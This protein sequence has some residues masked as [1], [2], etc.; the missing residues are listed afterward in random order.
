M[1]DFELLENCEGLSIVIDRG[2]EAI[3]EKAQEH[4]WLVQ[5]NFRYDPLLTASLNLQST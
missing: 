5:L 1:N 2:E 3:V 4:N